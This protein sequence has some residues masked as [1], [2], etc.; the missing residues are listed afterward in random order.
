M[1]HKFPNGFFLGKPIPAPSKVRREDAPKSYRYEP[2]KLIQQIVENI[3]AKYGLAMFSDAFDCLANWL[4]KGGTPPLCTD[5]GTHSS[6]QSRRVLYCH[7]YSIQCLDTSK[8]GPPFEFV[9]WTTRETAYDRW[10]LRHLDSQKAPR[11][12][13]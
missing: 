11:R 3:D 8:P 7:E 10:T 4:E 12:R 13:M 2:D 1:N 5:I 6:G 9:W